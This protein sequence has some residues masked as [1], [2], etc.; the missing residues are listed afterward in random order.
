MRAFHASWAAFFLCFFAWFGI[1]PLMPIVRDE[2]SLTKSQVGWCLIASVA[3]TI[4]ARV[5]VGWVCD[6]IGPRRAYSWLLILGSIPVMAIGLARDFETFLIFRLLIGAIGASFVITQYHTSLMFAPNCVGTATATTAGWGNLGGGATQI[7]MPLIFSLFVGVLGFSDFWGWRLSMFVAGAICLAAGVAYA[8]L[9]QDTPDGNFSDLRRDRQLD[10][11]A[12]RG[13]FALACRDGRTWALF[14]AY[15]ACFGV[16]LTL[17]NIA[18]LYFTD[19]F[20][21]GLHAAGLAAAAYGLMNLFARTLGGYISDRR[22]A[23]SG[24]RGRSIWLF[25]ALIGEGFALVAFSQASG[26]TTAVALLIVVGLFV[27]MSNGA[28]YAL[29]PFVNK[30]CTGSIAGIVGAG[31]NVGAVAAGFLFQ[32]AISWATALLFLGLTVLFLSM[33]AL[34]LSFAFA[35]QTVASSAEQPPQIPVLEAA[36]YV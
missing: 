13:A 34:A 28:T 4:V 3:I 20:G 22:G 32:G 35:R 36:G 21:L 23:R 2:F 33:S 30:N 10:S 15:A 17:K 11:A 26:L 14:I 24:L 9:T 12:K 19:Y 1:A 6:R 5:L 27:Q 25:T 16:E 31:G 29:V 8:R 7:V 18:A